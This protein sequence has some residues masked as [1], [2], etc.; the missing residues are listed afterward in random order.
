MKLHYEF[1]IYNAGKPAWRT[2]DNTGCWLTTHTPPTSMAVVSGTRTTD[3]KPL[4][5]MGAFVAEGGHGLQWL[6]ED[7]TKLGGQRWVGGHWTGAPTIAVD[8]QGRV[9]VAECDNYPR[10]V[11]VW[12]ANGK[13]VRAFYG[14]TEYGGGGVLDPQ[15]RARFFYKGMEFK[16]DWK[17]GVD[18]LVRVFARPNPL[19]AEHYGPYS[20]D[21]PLYPARQ[22]G[23]RYFTSCYTHIPTHGDDVA[24]TWLDGARQARLVAALGNAH[25]WFVLREAEFR[26]RWP[27]GTKPEEERPRREVS[28][29]FAWTDANNDGRPQPAEV[30][31]AKASC[32]GVTVMNDLSFVVSR[33]DGR[34][35][36]FPAT[37]DYT[38]VPRYALTK[39]E[40]LGPAGGWQP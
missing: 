26:S 22:K 21:T 39:P 3:G 7:G 19:L 38:G 12:T 36:R 6:H 37:F 23:R 4:I 40:D 29:A 18:S 2:A 20:P 28:A 31:F 34:N 8:T 13:L 10:R 11:S 30:Q 25:S 9:W 35:M 16:L 1:S 14:P 24:F 17:T 27:E 15:D 33:F 32:R 5:F